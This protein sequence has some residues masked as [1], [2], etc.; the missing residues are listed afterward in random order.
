[1]TPVH[2]QREVISVYI[3]NEKYG[4]LL[5]SLFLLGGYKTKCCISQTALQLLFLVHTR[6]SQWEG[7]GTEFKGRR[8]VAADT[9]GPVAGRYG[10]EGRRPSGSSRGEV[11]RAG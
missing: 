5:S 11:N 10:L 6:V 2:D 7:A 9:C 3:S 4:V 8:W 1:M